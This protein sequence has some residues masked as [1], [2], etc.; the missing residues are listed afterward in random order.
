MNDIEVAAK[1]EMN[2][3]TNE[4]AAK[5]N[6]IEQLTDQNSNQLAYLVNTMNKVHGIDEKIILVGTRL[7]GPDFMKDVV[8]RHQQKEHRPPAA[9]HFNN[10][11][12]YRAAFSMPDAV[13]S[14]TGEIQDKLDATAMI[15]G[16]IVEAIMTGP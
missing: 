5:K 2:R 14:A 13:N 12:F 3:R 15:L 8:D 6:I 10:S 11:S 4:P 7:F 1:A 16:D 9:E